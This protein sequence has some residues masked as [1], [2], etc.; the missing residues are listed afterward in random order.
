MPASTPPKLTVWRYTK[1]PTCKAG[2]DWQRNSFVRAARAGVIEFRDF[3]LRTDVLAS[4]SAA[5]RAPLG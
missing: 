2:I 3:N 5:G 1:C 4:F